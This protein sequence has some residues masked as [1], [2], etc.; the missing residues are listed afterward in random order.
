MRRT[1]R[2]RTGVTLVEAMIASA[3]LLLVSLSLFE[4]LI[5]SARI[6]KENSEYLAADAYAFDIA[7]RVFNENYATLTAGTSISADIR[8]NEVPVLSRPGW[9]VPEKQVDIENAANGRLITVDIYW[10][11]SSRRHKLSEWHTL[12]VL[13]SNIARGTDT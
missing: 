2:N 13:R 5:V 12:Q 8:T 1:R 11:P 3:V 10:G 4:G 9:P 6:A 7:W